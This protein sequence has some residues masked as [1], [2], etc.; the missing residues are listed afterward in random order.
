MMLIV[1]CG[2]VE[3]G[4]LVWCD[5]MSGV[6]GGR[7]PLGGIEEARARRHVG[8]FAELELVGGLG[9]GVSIFE[10]R[11]RPSLFVPFGSGDAAPSPTGGEQAA[12]HIR[13]ATRLH[14][15]RL[16]SAANLAWMR[17]AA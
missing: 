6:V 12:M 11:S 8:D 10:V 1:S 15:C 3:E 17:G 7:S 4:A 16:P 13:R 2:G 14:P 5:S 9:S